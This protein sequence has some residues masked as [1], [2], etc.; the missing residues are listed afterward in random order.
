MIGDLYPNI[1]QICLARGSKIFVLRIM[2][3][4]FLDVSIEKPT[5][6]YLVVDQSPV[7]TGFIYHIWSTKIRGYTYPRLRNR[8]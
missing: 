2:L 5:S 8:L 4:N 1:L 3:V 6:V 7:I